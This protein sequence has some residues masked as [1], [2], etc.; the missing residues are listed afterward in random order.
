MGRPVLH[1]FVRLPG[2][3]LAWHWGFFPIS[4]F[5]VLFGLLNF[6]EL[7]LGW[8]DRVPQITTYLDATA[9]LGREWVMPTLWSAKLV[10]AAI[11]MVAL[12]ALV[13]RDTRCLLMAVVGWLVVFTGYA[14]MDIWAADRAELLEHTSYFAAFSML[15]VVVLALSLMR[16]VRAGLDTRAAEVP[17]QRSPGR[18]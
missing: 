1:R 9:G 12:I 11:G 18:S 15:L 14:G 7:P 3:R 2:S 8:K 10:E 16:E 17:A 13:R 4:G 6:A 5:L